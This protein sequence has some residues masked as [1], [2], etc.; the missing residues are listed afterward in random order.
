MGDTQ[1]ING[2]IEHHLGKGIGV[3]RRS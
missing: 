3:S 2:E 1:S